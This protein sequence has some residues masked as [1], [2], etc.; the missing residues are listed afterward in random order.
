MVSAQRVELDHMSARDV[1]Q[2]SWCGDTLTAAAKKIWDDEGGVAAYTADE[3]NAADPY[4]TV[5]SYFNALRELGSARRIVEDEVRLRAT[6]YGSRQR[7]G[8]RWRGLRTGR[9]TIRLN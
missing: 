1:A 7:V 9:F 3:V 2:R 4:L 6:R 5:I 8:D